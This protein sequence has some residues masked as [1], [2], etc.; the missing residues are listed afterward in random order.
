MSQQIPK[1]WKQCATCAYW[2]GNRQPDHFLDRVTIGDAQSRGECLCKR[3]WF[4]QSRTA[5]GSCNAFRLWEVL[6]Q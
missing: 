6:D 5:S 4:H 2:D 3:G 1:S